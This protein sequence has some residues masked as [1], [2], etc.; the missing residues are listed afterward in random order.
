MPVSNLVVET[1]Q[2]IPQLVQA[3]I[4]LWAARITALLQQMPTNSAL[5]RWMIEF[6]AVESALSL[7]HI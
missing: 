5:R 6:R 1:R 3:V 2:V 4:V 7:I